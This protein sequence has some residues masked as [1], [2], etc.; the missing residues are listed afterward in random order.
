MNA[1]APT[2]V[3][4]DFSRDA[5]LTGAAAVAT[6]FGVHAAVAQ[7]RLGPQAFPHAPQFSASAV[8]LTHFRLQSTCGGVHVR[9]THWLPLQTFPRPQSASPQH[10]K[11]PD[12]AQ[13]VVPAPQEALNA[14]VPA[15]HVSVV[16][17][18]PSLHWDVL[19]HC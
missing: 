13:H 1:F 16:Q 11:H 19:Q 6:H 9:V 14:Q 7:L 5:K 17:G 4:A 2:A 3:D 10:A 18:L 15:L 8:G 12:P